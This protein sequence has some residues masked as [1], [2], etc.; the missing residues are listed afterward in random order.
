MGTFIKKLRKKQ[1]LNK[2]N[3]DKKHFQY[4]RDRRE[5]QSKEAKKENK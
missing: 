2:P 3:W 4:E 5:E 1:G